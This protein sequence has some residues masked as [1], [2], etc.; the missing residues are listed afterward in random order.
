MPY[1]TVKKI[2]ANLLV[3]IM[4]WYNLKHGLSYTYVRNI[5]RVFAIVDRTSG[6][7]HQ[8][9]WHWNHYFNFIFAIQVVCRR[10]YGTAALVCRSQC[11]LRL[12]NG[13]NMNMK[14]L[15]QRVRLNFSNWKTFYNANLTF[16]YYHEV[17][18]M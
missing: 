1:D 8:I 18:T 17:G 13:G 12:L 11:S 2:N 5:R 16:L 3:F 14:Y 10:S 4:M 15:I 6:E 9:L 7:L